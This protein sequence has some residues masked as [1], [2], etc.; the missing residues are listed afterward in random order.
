MVE[1]IHTMCMSQ[2]A[3]DNKGRGQAKQTSEPEKES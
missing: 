3:N 2:T 1:F